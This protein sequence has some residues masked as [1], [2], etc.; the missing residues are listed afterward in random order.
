MTICYQ[1]GATAEFPPE[2][3]KSFVG[4]RHKVLIALVFTRELGRGNPLS[5]YM[6]VLITAIIILGV[7]LWQMSIYNG[8][9]MM[10]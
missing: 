5:S 1:L 8:L 10:S 9:T 3:F 7:I 6:A 2:G 4:T